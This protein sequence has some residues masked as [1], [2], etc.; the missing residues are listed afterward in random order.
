MIK[1]GVLGAQGKMGQWIV[2]LLQ[3]EFKDEAELSYQASKQTPLAP[4]LSTEVVI[5]FASPAALSELVSLALEKKTQLPAFVVG[6]TGGTPQDQIQLEKLAQLTPVLV[7]SNFSIGVFI[8]AEILKNFSPLLA[9][10][11]YTPVLTETHHR[12]K[13][14][15]PSGTALSLQKVIQPQ[16]PSSI[17]THSI[18]AGEV[19]GDHEVT[20]YGLKDQISIRH[21]AQDRSIFARG[22]ISAGIWLVKQK[23]AHQIQNGIL[24][25][26]D[27]FQSLIPVVMAK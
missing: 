3:S 7:A 2:Q 20:F 27:Y 24:S 11:G 13:K 10:T 12:H 19:I 15:A 18:R 26:E 9:K 8:T 5:D 22:A 23:Q 4:L 21:H 16:Y 25:M 14:D 6:S 1:V 17:Q